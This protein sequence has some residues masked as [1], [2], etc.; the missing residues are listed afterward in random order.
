MKRT[1]VREIAIQLGFAV[2]SSGQDAREAVEA[3]TMAL[4]AVGGLYAAGE[5]LDADG[6]TGGCNLAWAFA[7]A[8][9]AV[10]SCLRR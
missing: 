4:K 10:Q 3:K 1:A 2:V 5:I 9:L 6:P 7:S 8:A